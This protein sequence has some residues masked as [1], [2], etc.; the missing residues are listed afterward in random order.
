MPDRSPCL[1]PLSWQSDVAGCDPSLQR[2]ILAARI[3]INDLFQDLRSDEEYEWGNPIS[4][5]NCV[6][7]AAFLCGVLRDS[8]PDF[9]WVPV[10]GREQHESHCVVMGQINGE[11]VFA[12][13]TGD[14][15]GDHVSSAR[16]MTYTADADNSFV[17][18][19]KLNDAL[20]NVR[21]LEKW[22]ANWCQNIDRHRQEADEIMN[23]NL[24]TQEYSGIMSPGVSA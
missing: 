9:D 21:I 3:C 18:K 7:G 10:V 20:P 14:Q 16:L 11:R 6:E 2:E 4:Y 23:S 12:D 17:I 24:P 22:K 5:Q 19:L 15:F 13:I 8:F 1:A